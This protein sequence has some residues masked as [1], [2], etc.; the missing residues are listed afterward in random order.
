MT[1]AKVLLCT[2][3]SCTAI[4]SDPLFSLFIPRFLSKER[5]LLE[6]QPNQQ[7]AT[8]GTETLPTG[9]RPSRFEI[10]PV[11]QN[12]VLEVP[13]S[14]SEASSPEAGN[15][16]AVKSILKSSGSSCPGPD[17]EDKLQES[18]IRQAIDKWVRS[19]TP[20]GG[21]VSAKEGKHFRLSITKLSQ[22]G[23]RSGSYSAP[24][25]PSGSR[26]VRVVS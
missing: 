2:S 26:R 6:N 11:E 19:I 1:A 3:L 18:R 25:S 13:T 7:R 22:T 9:R 5:R 20:T 12:N 8:D 14:R 17:T 23:R 16:H 4:T 15:N 24:C 10:T 21:E